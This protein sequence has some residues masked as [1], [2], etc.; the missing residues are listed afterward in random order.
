MLDSA[1]TP[2]AVSHSVYDR[3][4]DDPNFSLLVE[5]IDFVDLTD[6]VDRTLPI[7]FLAPDNT[8]WRRIVFG[9]TQGGEIVKRHIFRG[10]LFLDVI[11]NATQLTDVNGLTHAV[12]LRGEFNESLWVGGGNVY[13]GDILARN[14]ILHYIDR[15][16]GEPF[17]EGTVPPTM[18]PQP[19]ITPEPTIVIP[20][21]PAP[22]VRPTGS[23][24]IYL[25][26]IRAPTMQEALDDSN[27][28]TPDGS[29]ASSVSAIA[30][31]LA[32]VTFVVWGM[33]VY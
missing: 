14:G 8:A 19:T 10:L 21:S 11:R 6:L 23:A 27:K 28:E 33:I 30:T 13:E 31:I 16:I 17:A 7:T 22:I 1:I 18:S 25:P 12:E 32:S 29:S 20:P 9:T 15:V 26:P 5:N 2:T 24:P 4:R 3:S